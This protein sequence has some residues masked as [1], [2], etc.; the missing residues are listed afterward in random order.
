MEHD[1]MQP[2]Q[3]TITN[4][5]TLWYYVLDQEAIAYIT[6]KDIVTR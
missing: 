3:S 5:L 4:N 2:V 6:N 1:E